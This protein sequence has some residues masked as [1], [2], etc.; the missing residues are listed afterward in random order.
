[1]DELVTMNWLCLLPPVSWDISEAR[2]FPHTKKGVMK[3][4]RSNLRR[5]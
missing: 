2:N 3:N 4:E 1:M 5:N